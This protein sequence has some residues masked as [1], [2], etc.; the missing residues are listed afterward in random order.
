MLKRFKNVAG[1]TLT[2]L[3]VASVLMGIVMIGVISFSLAIKQIQQ[4]G[5]ST[6]FAQMKAANIINHIRRNAA[7]AIGY[8]NNPGVIE[9]DETDSPPIRPPGQTSSCSPFYFAF[10][11]DINLTPSNYSDDRW[12][13]YTDGNIPGKLYYCYQTGGPFPQP[14]VDP[15]YPY[16]P[17]FGAGEP[18]ELTKAQLLADNVSLTFNFHAD[19]SITKQELFF[20]ITVYV[21]E[22]PTKPVD[23]V[24]NPEYSMTIHVYPQSSSW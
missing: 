11:H 16:I 14:G 22:D 1:I 7:S 12:I 2:E 21:P 20:E 17:K 19:P 8:R 18:C 15:L 3:I 4:S 9:C 23:P 6:I 10:R 5:S 13:I 24:T